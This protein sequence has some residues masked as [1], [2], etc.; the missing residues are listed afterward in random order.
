[1][2]IFPTSHGIRIYTEEP[3]PERGTAMWIKTD[4]D[5]ACYVDLSKLDTVYVNR[6][7]SMNYAI[8]G[9]IVDRDVFL[10]TRQ[11]QREAEEYL[12][13]VMKKVMS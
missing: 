10:T 6:R 1:M 4:A 8:I 11:N 13:E 3:E 9:R 5:P 7:G 12:E 2:P